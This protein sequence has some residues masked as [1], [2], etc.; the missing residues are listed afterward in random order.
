[1]NF[2]SREWD[3]HS[4]ETARLSDIIA[5]A[6]ADANHFYPGKQ[7]PGLIYDAS[8]MP[9]KVTG[10]TKALRHAFSELFLNALQA[11]PKQPHDYRARN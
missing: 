7:A 3:G 9:W 4:G 2:L 6:Y 8:A 10:D 11:N 1:M 5:N